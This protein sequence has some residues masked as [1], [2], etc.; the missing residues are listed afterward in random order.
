MIL[1]T[2]LGPRGSKLGPSPEDA[3]LSAKGM[4]DYSRTINTFGWSLKKAVKKGLVVL[5]V[6]LDT[7]QIVVR[8]V[9][10]IGS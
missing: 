4:L 1:P 10:K 7:K 9:V 5:A 3:A 6:D 2:K 8:K